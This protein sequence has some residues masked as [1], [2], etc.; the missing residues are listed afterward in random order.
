MNKHST[1]IFVKLLEGVIF[2]FRFNLTP[3][4]ISFDVE[5][6]FLSYEKEG[7]LKLVVRH[8]GNA[9]LLA[10]LKPPSFRYTSYAKL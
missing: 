3:W 10:A 2:E 7:A 5:N 8:K 6:R 9:R 1:L 4:R